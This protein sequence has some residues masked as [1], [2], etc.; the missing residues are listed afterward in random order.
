M[1]KNTLENKVALITGAA[2]FIGSHLAERLFALGHSVVGLDCLTDY[3]ARSLKELNLAEIQAKGIHV[4][5]LDLAVS[6]LTAA[7]QDVDVVYHCAAQ[8]G[9]SGATPYKT[10]VRN[11]LTAT[12]RLLQAARGALCIRGF[13]FLSTS[14]VYGSDAT[15]PETSEPRPTSY[16]G[17]TK[18]AAEQLALAYARDQ[19]FPAC[20]LRLFSVYGPR[21]RPEKLFPKLIGAVLDDREF[22]LF[23]GSEAHVRS[24]TYVGDIIDGLVAVL[25]HLEDCVG[26]I[27]NIGTDTAITT[28]EA[29]AIVEEL[30]G[31]RARIVRVPKR[32]GD[33]LRTHADI[34]KARRMLGYDPSTGPREGL[35]E[36]VRWYRER[37]LRSDPQ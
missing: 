8:P 12:F 30:I 35:A 13:V 32:P 21:E 27:L 18:L 1:S 17:V 31:K 10:Y 11:N 20:S 22:P 26:E 34:F 2:G 33:Q 6:D 37:I 5:P 23:E 36:E 19:G 15:G 16:Y 14:S 28:G 7:V 24:Y 29:I 3:Y 25:A 9:I 4:L